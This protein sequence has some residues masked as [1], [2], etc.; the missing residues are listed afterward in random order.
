MLCLT[1]SHRY[2]RAGVWVQQTSGISPTS[3]E[4]PSRTA[5]QIPG[6]LQ[7]WSTTHIWDL[8]NTYGSCSLFNWN[9]RVFCCCCYKLNVIHCVVIFL[10]KSPWNF[11]FLIDVLFNVIFNQNNWIKQEISRE[12]MISFT[13]QHVPPST[14]HTWD[15][16]AVKF[17]Y[18]SAGTD[19]V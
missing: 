4:I 18:I 16:D 2:E 12:R 7:R 13:T 17:K 9:S 5:S 11:F 15:P 3:E 10:L 1:Y 19:S 8:L 14:E 6:P